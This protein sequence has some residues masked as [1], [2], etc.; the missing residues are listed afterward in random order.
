MRSALFSLSERF[1][2]IPPQSS[3]GL[4]HEF[5]VAAFNEI[6]SFSDDVLQDFENLAHAGFPVNE[7]RGVL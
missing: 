3:T 1:I 2:A 7:F 5:R 4:C 6:A